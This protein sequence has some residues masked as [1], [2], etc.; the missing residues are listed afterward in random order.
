MIL[1]KAMKEDTL[2]TIWLKKFILANLKPT[3]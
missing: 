2:K 3:Y 1:N